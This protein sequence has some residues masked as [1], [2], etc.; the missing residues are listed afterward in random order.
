M[1]LVGVSNSG[2]EMNDAGE[3]G[4]E[5]AEEHNCSMGVVSAED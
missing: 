2:L 1:E 5:Q 3:Y 4:G